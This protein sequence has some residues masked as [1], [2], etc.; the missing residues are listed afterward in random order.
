MKNLMIMSLD[1]V[2]IISFTGIFV[3]IILLLFSNDEEIKNNFF[4]IKTKSGKIVYSLEQTYKKRLEKSIDANTYDLRFYAQIIDLIFIGMLVIISN[5]YSNQINML[6]IVSV[7][8]VLFFLPIIL[9]RQS[10]GQK[11]MHLKVY[12]WDNEPIK[13]FDIIFLRYLLKYLVCPISL[14]TV[15]KSKFLFH[16]IIFKTYEK[17]E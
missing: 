16:D 9:W 10:I 13:D 14:I 12:N 7:S 8:I 11:F 2:L 3:G 5:Y 4:T 17:Q 1:S 15:S 6:L